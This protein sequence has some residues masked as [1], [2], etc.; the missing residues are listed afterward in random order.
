MTTPAVPD[1]AR[2][3]TG[4]PTTTTQPAPESTDRRATR[5]RFLMTPPTEFDVVYA[6][7]AWMDPSRPVDTALAMRQ[8]EDLVAVYESLG[9]DV[10]RATPGPGLPDMVF[11]ANGGVV[12]GGIAVGARFATAER[13]PEAVLY[14][15]ALFAAGVEVV[16][17]PTHVNEGEGDYVV[18]GDTILA[19]TGFRTDRRA[20]DELA[21]LTGREVVSLQLDD[22]RFYHLDVA[23]FAL[24]DDNVAYY[25]GA[26]DAAGRAELERRWPDAVLADEHDAL[27]LGCNAVSDGRHVVVAHEATSLIGQLAA[28]GFVPI[29][30]DLSEFR[31]SGG[32]VKCCTM[33]LR[34]APGAT[35]LRPAPGA[36]ELRPAPGVTEE[37]A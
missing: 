3:I 28:R 7:N 15:E 2:A 29:P 27:V 4:A 26:F 21:R 17:E 5:R 34:P 23:V 6:I 9:H 16:H 30:V 35:E 19:G 33:E 24:D 13:G 18:V 11:A 14:R 22:P 31:K 37:S 25:P 32:G 12:V 20:H 8:W 36:T 10:V 1:T